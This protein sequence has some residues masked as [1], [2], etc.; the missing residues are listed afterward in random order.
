MSLVILAIKGSNTE[1]FSK[2]IEHLGVT[3]NN[4]NSESQTPVDQNAFCSK[5]NQILQSGDINGLITHI[6]TLGDVLIHEP[7]CIVLK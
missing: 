1:Q 6:I 7:K 4:Y 2:F 3:I 5:A